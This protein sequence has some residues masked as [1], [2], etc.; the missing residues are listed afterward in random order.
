M[1]NKIIKYWPNIVSVCGFLMMLT[2]LALAYYCNSIACVLGF[3]VSLSVYGLGEFA[4]VYRSFKQET[5]GSR[6]SWFSILKLVAIALVFFVPQLLALAGFLIPSIGLLLVGW[7]VMVFGSVLFV[8]GLV[9][10]LIH[11][12][13]YR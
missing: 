1:K 4:S 13:I 3:I 12:L 8:V 6:A 2:F 9:L 11:W 10:L 7:V 5:K